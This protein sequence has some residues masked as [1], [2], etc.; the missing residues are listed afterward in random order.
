MTE[1]PEDAWATA[2][3]GLDRGRGRRRSVGRRVAAQR[4]AVRAR[5]VGRPDP[6]GGC[7]GCGPGPRLRR[8]ARRRHRP[9]RP[10]RSQR[11]VP[12]RRAARRRRGRARGHRHGA[13]GATGPAEVARPDAGCRPARPRRG[14]PDGRG[15]RPDR[16][17]RG[18]EDGARRGR[19]DRRYRRRGP[20]VGRPTRS[21]AASCSPSSNPDGDGSGR[22]TRFDDGGCHGPAQDRDRARSGAHTG[23][24]PAPADARRAARPPPRDEAAPERRGARQPE[25]VAAIALLGRIEVEVAR[26]ERAMDPPL[27]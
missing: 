16:H 19:V 8:R 7:R 18:D 1:I 10:R 6:N 11:P 15:R 24:D 17:P 2:A 13:A 27:V 25:H 3:T 21:P 4:P 20:R 5:R 23:S 22:L 9:P 12:A 14:R 26:I